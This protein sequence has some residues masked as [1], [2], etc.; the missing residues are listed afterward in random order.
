MF[1][2]I[3]PPRATDWHLDHAAFSHDLVSEWPAVR[4]L[5]AEPDSPTRSLV[6][7]M[8]DPGGGSSWIEG[9]LDR[10]GQA[11]Y[12]R[13]DL[14]LAA[15]FARWLRGKVDRRQP[16]VFSDE[17]FTHVVELVDDGSVES[18]LRAYAT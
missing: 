5:P 16:L 13:G 9:S 18:I 8:D 3:S 1:Y 4:V 11:H 15:E 2:V 6:W 17:A 12:L 10:A 7:A 14:A